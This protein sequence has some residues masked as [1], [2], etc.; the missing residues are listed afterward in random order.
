MESRHKNV[1]FDVS[2]KPFFKGLIISPKSFL[3]FLEME[4]SVKCKLYYYFKRPKD[5]F[6]RNLKNNN[7]LV[8]G[9]VIKVYILK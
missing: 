6:P 9:M 7:R 2:C 5:T 3:Y 4:K 8:V 1:T